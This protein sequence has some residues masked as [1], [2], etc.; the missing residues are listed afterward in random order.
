ML[1]IWLEEW[2]A[3]EGAVGTLAIEYDLTDGQE[4]HIDID[5]LGGPEE[6]PEDGRY[7]FRRTPRNGGDFHYKTSI[8]LEEQYDAVL[9]VRTRWN[10]DGA[11]RADARV[12][13]RDMG[14]TYH[15]YQCFTPGEPY[16]WRWTDFQSGF[17]DGDP[18]TCVFEEPATIDQI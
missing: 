6:R 8:L 1:D 3:I 7:Y 9:E 17:E 12:F 13:L 15:F 5:G 11:G 18:S 2:F 14:Q 4:F 16:A 10:G